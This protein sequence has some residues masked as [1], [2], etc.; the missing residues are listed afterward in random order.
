A[1][2]TP[3]LPTIPPSVNPGPRLAP[4]GSLGWWTAGSSSMP[5][6]SD[7]LLEPGTVA[8]LGS[9]TVDGGPCLGASIGLLGK[10][11]EGTFLD[12]Q[13]VFVHSVDAVQRKGTSPLK[14][15]QGGR[16]QG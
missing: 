8:M 15:P 10:A 16:P 4:P 6:W 12:R 7:A 1:G 9:G 14:G 13:V 2:N 3:T 11:R 5:A